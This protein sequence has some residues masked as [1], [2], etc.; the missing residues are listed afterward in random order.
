MNRNVTHASFTITRSWKAS[1]VRVFDA[2]S[3]EENKRQ[4]FARAPGGEVQ[5]KKFDFREGGRRFWRA[6]IPMA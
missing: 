5:E 6:A 1:P 3:Q 4:W 2:F